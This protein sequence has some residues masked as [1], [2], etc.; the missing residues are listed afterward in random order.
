MG[1]SGMTEDE[2][3][4]AK[5]RTDI[6][7]WLSTKPASYPQQYVYQLFIKLSKIQPNETDHSLFYKYRQDFGTVVKIFRHHSGRAKAADV[8]AS[9]IHRLHSPAESGLMCCVISSSC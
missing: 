7:F 2:H 3:L 6:Y 8:V 5:R 4:R 9:G 1:S